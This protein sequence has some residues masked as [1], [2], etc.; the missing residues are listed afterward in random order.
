[1]EF[2]L[3]EQADAELV[4]LQIRGLRPRA[5]ETQ[6]ILG[7]SLAVTAAKTIRNEDRQTPTI[8]DGRQGYLQTPKS[9]CPGP[10]VCSRKP[11]TPPGPGQRAP[12]TVSRGAR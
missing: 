3:A 12:P 11:L 8:R 1:M 4:E 5:H 10:T 7:L 9:Q 2:M 6:F